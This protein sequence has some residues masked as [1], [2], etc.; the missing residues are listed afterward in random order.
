M[1]WGGR[2]LCLLAK[3]E[4]GT[5][6]GLTY[7]LWLVRGG[8]CNAAAFQAKGWVGL[9]CHFGCFFYFPNV[10]LHQGRGY[11]FLHFGE[12]FCKTQRG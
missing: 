11:L 10:G 12:L 3:M 8:S 1:V 2:W 5:W 9:A 7:P 4:S 6:P